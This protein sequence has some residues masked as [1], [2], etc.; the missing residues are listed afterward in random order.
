MTTSQSP[1]LGVTG[2]VPAGH[3]PTYYEKLGEQHDGLLRCHDCKRLATHAALIAA[4]GCPRCGNR[5][6]TEVT[7]LSLFE[8]LRVRLGLLDFPHRD[9][10]LQEFSRGRR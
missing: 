10:F 8:W 9:L 5:K 3:V 4:H 6:V 1:L 2:D 7:T